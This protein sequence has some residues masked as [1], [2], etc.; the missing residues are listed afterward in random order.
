MIYICSMKTYCIYKLET[1]FGRVYI[2]QT[3]NIQSRFAQYKTIKSHTQPLLSKS[4]IKYGW[5]NIKKEILFDS[6]SKEEA[7]IKE[8]ELI[9]Y[10]KS[11]QISLNIATGG[12]SGTLK[13]IIQ[14]DKLGT[15]IKEWNSVLEYLPNSFSEQNALR[16]A[17][18]QG[19][20]NSHYKGFLWLYKDEYKQ[21]IFPIP[22]IVDNPIVQ[23]KM[24]GEFI[25]EYLHIREACYI[26]GLKYHN[27]KKC[28]DRRQH[29][30]KGYRWLYKETYLKIKDTEE[31]ELLCKSKKKSKNYETSIC[32]L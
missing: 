3:Y 26:T 29:Y 18:N 9:A 24:N 25:K 31:F 17:L 10:Y 2:G 21:G 16:K 6:L 19:N 27:I 23:L 15:F 5:D 14:F 7:N 12:E 30:G 22:T 4:I 28:V 20:G 13:P 1:P 8:I 32:S 11:Q